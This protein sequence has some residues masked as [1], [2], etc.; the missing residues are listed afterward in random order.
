MVWIGIC[1][2]LRIYI[3]PPDPVKCS[4]RGFGV[5]VESFF[6][7]MD[8]VFQERSKLW[9][10]LGLGLGYLWS[11][12]PRSGGI[13]RVDWWRPPCWLIVSIFFSRFFSVAVGGVVFQVFVSLLL[14][15]RE[16]CERRLLVY[17][18]VFPNE[19][20]PGVQG[21]A[22]ISVTGCGS[23]KNWYFQ[24][25]RMPRSCGESGLCA[26]RP[27]QLELYTPFRW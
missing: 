14:V 8:A 11:T 23:M 18:V 9:L 26:W 25:L 27:P 12:T 22:A 20:H 21:G 15:P 16:P 10:G 4:C 5:S 3:V 24:A 1:S 13:G 7:N 6:D 19:P 17:S 2:K